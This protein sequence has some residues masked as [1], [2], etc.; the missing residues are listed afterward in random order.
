MLV[1]EQ[2]AYPSCLS[3]PYAIFVSLDHRTEPHNQLYNTYVSN[4]IVESGGVN[5]TGKEG[6]LMIA[7]AYEA[8]EGGLLYERQLHFDPFFA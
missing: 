8:W 2:H 7:A 4:L 1:L 6:V 3:L 5:S